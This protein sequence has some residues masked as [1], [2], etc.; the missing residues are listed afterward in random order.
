M[1]QIGASAATIDTPIEHLM[2][3][4]RRIEQRLETLINAA[5]HMGIDRAGA[6]KAIRKSLE[7]LDTSGALH[8][9]DEE[10]SLF[11]RLR[12][13][14]SSSEVVFV[15]S[16]EAQHVEAGAVYADLKQLATTLNSPGGSSTD[17]IA[18]YRDC[19]SRLRA[20]YRDHIRAEDEI[21]TALAKRSLG[22]L[23]ISEISR[24]MRARRATHEK[25]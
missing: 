10:A 3:C 2:A 21:L 8:T 6:L 9:Q 11:P 15:D 20:L 18:S 19:A 12:P 7:F 24:E 1:I 4:H 22:E 5:G 16:L 13:K 25:V 17:S 14:L 23:D